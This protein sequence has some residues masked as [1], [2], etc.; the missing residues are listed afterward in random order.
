MYSFRRKTNHSSSGNSSETMPTFVKCIRKAVN[1]EESQRPWRSNIKA[2]M[3]PVIMISLSFRSPCTHQLILPVQGNRWLFDAVL[4][5]S[6][7]LM[8]FIL[9]SFLLVLQRPHRSS[10]RSMGQ[11]PT[12]YT[13]FLEIKR[14][15]PYL[16]APT[17]HWWRTYWVDIILI[18]AGCLC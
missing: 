5:G 2:P 18:W 7:T 1:T 8:L 3:T 10:M 6:Y 4:G 9:P 14:G 16:W 11:E 17:R 12:V 13:S 15:H